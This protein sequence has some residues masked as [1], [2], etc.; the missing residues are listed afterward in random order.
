MYMNLN[1]C[2]FCSDSSVLTP[3]TTLLW[4]TI[5]VFLCMHPVVECI[6]CDNDLIVEYAMRFKMPLVSCLV[7]DLILFTQIWGNVKQLKQ[8]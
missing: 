3:Q 2:F 5:F 1:G 4:S 6:E 7:T 8:I